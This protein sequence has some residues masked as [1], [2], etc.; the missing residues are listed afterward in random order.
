MAGETVKLRVEFDDAQAK[1]G[2]NN[3]IRSL[4]ASGASVT[5]AAAGGGG[6][7]DKAADAIGK[8]VGAILIQQLG[9]QLTP[10]MQN[11]LNP[12]AT[13]RQRE[14]GLGRAGLELGGAGIGA[15]IGSAIPGIGT[16]VGA[17]V[18][19]QI[20]KLAGELATLIDPKGKEVNASI[21]NVLQQEAATR[22]RLGI[23]L[24][25]DE[26]RRIGRAEKAGAEAEFDARQRAIRVT[27]E[28]SP[29][30]STQILMHL[31]LVRGRRADSGGFAFRDAAAQL[32]DDR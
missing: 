16:V 7:S 9:Q 31:G 30:W 19:Q 2:V 13:A 5:K 12:H 10:I 18:G 25:T 4:E 32:T 8:S 11:A 22:A 6:G 29:S 20:G 3:L 21:S 26:L 17:A 1:A 24:N 23:P 27:D 15:A 14:E 28:I